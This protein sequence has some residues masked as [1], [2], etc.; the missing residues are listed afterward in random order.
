MESHYTYH[1]YNYYIWLSGS[2]TTNESL[3]IKYLAFKDFFPRLSSSQT[4]R[5][6]F[7]PKFVD[8]ADW[9]S[10]LYL[11][12]LNPPSLCSSLFVNNLH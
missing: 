2:A 12:L 8:A 9:F 6:C 3:I 11:T 5:T 4:H 7:K 10:S 1:N